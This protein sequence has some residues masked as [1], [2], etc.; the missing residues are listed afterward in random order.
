MWTTYVPF[1]A[2][3]AEFPRISRSCLNNRLRF[4]SI[5]VACGLNPTDSKGAFFYDPCT[6]VPM[7]M[8]LPEGE[9]AG[10]RVRDLVQPHDLAATLL[11][12]AGMPPAGVAELMP[13]VNGP[14]RPGPFRRGLP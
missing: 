13:P 6:R 2:I 3:Y 12:A 5:W 10:N 1:S 4:S 7:I 8:R 9:L 14:G 11:R